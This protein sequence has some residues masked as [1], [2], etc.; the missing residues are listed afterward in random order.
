MAKARHKAVFLDR[1]GT[2]SRDVPYCSCPEDF[3]LLPMVAE[4]I[5]LFNDY[6]FK[7]VVV[8]NQS[9][10]GRGYFSETM[11]TR[12]HRKM[13]DEL[14]KSGVTIDAIYYCPHRPDDNCDCRKPNPKMILQAAQALKIDLERSYIIGDSDTD[15]QMGDKAGCQTILINTE[16]MD[17]EDAC[18]SVKPDYITRSVF[19][20]ARLIIA[21]E[22]QGS[23]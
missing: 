17:R 4:G 18:L 16:G 6:G 1:D 23:G 9:G 15:I 20:A 11:L 3:E 13:L 2:I 22:I 19:A 21:A 5:K 10:V 12:I 8:T 7:V 14:K